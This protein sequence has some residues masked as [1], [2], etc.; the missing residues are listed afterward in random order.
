MHF[1]KIA[2]Q[3]NITLFIIKGKIITLEYIAKI[4]GVV[5]DIKFWYKQYIIKAAIKGFTVV[6]ALKR[7]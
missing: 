4:L 2:D 7:F 3:T 6:I 5:M 1:T